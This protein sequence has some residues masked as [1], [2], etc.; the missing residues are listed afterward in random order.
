M[1]LGGLAACAC[2]GGPPILVNVAGA[3]ASDQ[4][5]LATGSDLSRRMTAPVRING[6]GPFAFAVDTGANRT[7]I[8][9]ELAGRLGLPPGPAANVHGVAGVERA[10]TAAIDRL[11][12]GNVASQKLV[13][14]ALSRARLGVDGLLG[15]DVFRNRRVL[16]NFIENR[17]IISADQAAASSVFGM[18]ET[19]SAGLGANLGRRVVVPARYRFG[20]LIIIGADMAR[21]PVTAF[22]D[23]GSESTVG[24]TALRRLAYDKGGAPQPVRFRVPVLSA[25]GQT[26]EGELGT[27]PLLRIG[28]LNITG[29]TTVFADLHVFE[30]WDLMDRPSLLLGMDV[31]RQFNAIEL[32]YARRQVAFHLKG[33]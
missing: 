9:L 14:P 1:A 20:Q 25:T 7:V 32:N 16:M 6:E 3:Q 19:A 29:M 8:S 27:M 26:A 30:L 28:G 13:A 31:M 23:S 2:A 4:A 11:E 5:Q 24:N 33:T 22:V 21:R 18:R 12:V 15:V 17:L 10:E